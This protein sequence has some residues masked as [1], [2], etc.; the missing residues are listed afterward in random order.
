MTIPN[1]KD[2]ISKPEISFWLPIIGYVISITVWG[3]ILSNKIELIVQKFD[4]FEKQ[5]E[6]Q[7]T[8][9]NRLAD[10]VNYYIGEL[11]AHIGK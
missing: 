4:A 3:M 5:N 9:I 6:A 7:N 11:R 1:H 10:S 8:R 2:L